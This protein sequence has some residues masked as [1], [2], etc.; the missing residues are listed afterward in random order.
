MSSPEKILKYVLQPYLLCI[1]LSLHL[2]SL[3]I[4]D[5]TYNQTMH[6]FNIMKLFSVKEPDPRTL[7]REFLIKSS[8]LVAVEH[9]MMV[10]TQTT[11]G[12]E[13]AEKEYKDVSEDVLYWHRK[14][15]QMTSECF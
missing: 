14:A 8:S 13:K 7:S 5:N 12:L 4:T 2:F 3:L 10:F 11:L 6:R 1:V 9:V 15:H